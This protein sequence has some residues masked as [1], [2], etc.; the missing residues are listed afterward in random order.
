MKHLHRSVISAG[1]VGTLAIGLFAGCTQSGGAVT[2]RPEPPAPEGDK[3]TSATNQPKGGKAPR[4]PK[5]AAAEEQE[6]QGGQ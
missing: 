1:I 6:V 5:T 3:T 4:S 2:P